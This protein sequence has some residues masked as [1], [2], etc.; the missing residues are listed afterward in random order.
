MHILTPHRRQNKILLF[1][2]NVVH[3]YYATTFCEWIKWDKSED[4]DVKI[5]FNSS[6]GN[7]G[8]MEAVN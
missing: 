7:G 2:Y 5:E 8:L 4:N 1:R 6:L 3:H